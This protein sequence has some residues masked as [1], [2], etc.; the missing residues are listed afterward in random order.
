[1][2]HSALGLYPTNG[3]YYDKDVQKALD[4]ASLHVRLYAPL[5]YVQVPS[6]SFWGD[7]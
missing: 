3:A 7:G 1:M 6:F 2:A 5:A 4:A